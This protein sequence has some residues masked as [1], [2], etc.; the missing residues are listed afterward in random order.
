MS[1]GQSRSPIPAGKKIWKE[2]CSGAA[3]QEAA[4]GAVSLTQQSQKLS[5]DLSML[6]KLNEGNM[7]IADVCDRIIHAAANEHYSIAELCERIDENHDGSITP[8]ELQATSHTIQTTP[9]PT[10][11]AVPCSVV[12][13]RAGM[14]NMITKIDGWSR[15]VGWMVQQRTHLGDTK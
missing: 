4:D 7:K 13:D 6:G 12:P 9:T 5:D 2:R 14:R 11:L 15:P 10:P 8:A 1:D 3:G